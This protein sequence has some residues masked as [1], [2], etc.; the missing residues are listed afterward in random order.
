MQGLINSDLHPALCLAF[1]VPFIP[2]E[3][4]SHRGEIRK[5][6]DEYGLATEHF[7]E[8]FVLFLFGAVNGGVS[9]DSVRL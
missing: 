6:L 4:Q 3:I 1:I 9:L 7:V 5:P 2:H 8:F